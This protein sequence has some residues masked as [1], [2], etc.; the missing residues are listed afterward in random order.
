MLDVEF[1]AFTSE[2]VALHSV[3]CAFGEAAVFC[4]TIHYSAAHS[5]T[6]QLSEKV[7]SEVEA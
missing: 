3:R 2:Y 4:V 5:A 1:P 7:L 6:E